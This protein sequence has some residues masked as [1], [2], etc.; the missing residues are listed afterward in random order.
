MGILK[1]NLNCKQYKI[2][3]ESLEIKSKKN[4]YS[5]L[6][7]P[8]KYNVEKWGI[9]WKKLLE[10]EESPMPLFRNLTPRKT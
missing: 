5:D 9:L 7:D 4:S 6:I 2:L 1:K 3:F 10:T 8:Y